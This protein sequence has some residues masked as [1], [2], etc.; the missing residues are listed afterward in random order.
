MPTTDIR[1][2]NQ[3]A[4]GVALW[5]PRLSGGDFAV[6]ASDE[7]HIALLLYAEPGNF[8]QSPLVGVGLRGARPSRGMACCRA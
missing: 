5:E 7:Q 2:D 4:A 1:L 8:R 3:S 6:E